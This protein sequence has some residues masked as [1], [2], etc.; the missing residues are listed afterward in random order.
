MHWDQHKVV[1]YSVL[2]Q[3]AADNLATIDPQNDVERDQKKSLLNILLNKRNENCEQNILYRNIRATFPITFT[4]IE[5]IKRND[6]RN[7]SKQLHRFTADAI[8]AALRELQCEGIAAIPHVDA[9][10]CQEKN[11]ERVCDVLGR[12]IFEATGVCC[13]RCRNCRRTRCHTVSVARGKQA[14]VQRGYALKQE[15]ENVATATV[16]AMGPLASSTG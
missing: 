16:L 6:H 10:I 3:S 4:I 14:E 9:L 2:E 1:D 7:L 13:V 8:A 5:D 15:P 12:Q 11:G